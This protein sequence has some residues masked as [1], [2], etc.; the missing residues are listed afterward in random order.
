MRRNLYD[1][2]GARPDDDAEQLRK[3]FL[4]AAKESHPDHHG[5]DPDT[6]ARF[7]QITE[8]Y[9]ILRDA[10]QRAAYDRLLNAE[11]RPIRSKMNGAFA[12]AK[13]HLVIDAMIGILIAAVLAGSY[14]LY[15]RVSKTAVDESAG[16]TTHDPA[17][18]AAGQPP[19]QSRTMARDRPAVA[20]AVQM[21][22]EN[23]VTPAD[24]APA[25]QAIEIARNDSS[26]DIPADRAG[27]QAGPDA[28]A[29]RT[30]EREDRRDA[31]AAGGQVAAAATFSGVPGPPSTDVASPANVPGRDTPESTGAGPHLVKQPAESA[32]TGV[33]ARIRGAMGRASASRASFRQ[34]TPARRNTLARMHA[35]YCEDDAPPS[36]GSR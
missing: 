1:L 2:L 28:S 26:S 9:D 20:P 3:A 35:R 31:P 33:S 5:D 10:E 32:E 30:D 13:R 25:R 12:D 19:G 14:Q 17:G 4:K 23:P 29:K 24:A 8:A 15:A 11:R 34:A 16:M 21:P 6:V 7:R 27:A 36:F 18:I 22:I